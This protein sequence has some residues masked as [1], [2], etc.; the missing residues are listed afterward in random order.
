MIASTENVCE[1]FFLDAINGVFLARIVCD[2]VFDPY[3]LLG[4]EPNP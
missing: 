3:P 1:F 2:G 4:L